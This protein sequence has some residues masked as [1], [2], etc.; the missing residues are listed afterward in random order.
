ML[1]GAF[2]RRRV[3]AGE[4]TLKVATGGQGPPVVL[5][6]GYPQTQVCWHKV[7]P[8][9]ALDFPDAVRRLA[10]FDVLPTLDMWEAMDRRPGAGPAHPGPGA[11]PVAA[12][13]GD[14]APL[15]PAGRVAPL[16]RRGVPGL[17]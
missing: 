2:A 17:S 16:G 10:L 12:A 5:L 15:R 11:G 6:H 13:P 9:L 4:V 3:Q 8:R 14:G 1:P 7:A